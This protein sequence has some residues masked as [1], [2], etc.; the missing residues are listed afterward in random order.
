MPRPRTE[1]TEAPTEIIAP[2]AVAEPEVTP[3]PPDTPT[4][5]GSLSATE[6]QIAPDGHIVLSQDDIDAQT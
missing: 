1:D 4:W 2:A 6:P 5:E 3:D